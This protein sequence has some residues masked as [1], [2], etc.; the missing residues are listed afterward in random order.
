MVSLTR[1]PPLKPI[2]Q[3]LV[4]P[5]IYHSQLKQSD[6]PTSKQMKRGT[7]DSIKLLAALIGKLL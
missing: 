7:K 6:G 4:L 2:K 5:K 3:T 1:R